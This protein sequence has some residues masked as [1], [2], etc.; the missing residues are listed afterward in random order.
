MAERFP[1]SWF[2]GFDHSDAVIA[3]ARKAADH[4]GL[5]DRVSFEVAGAA[6]FPAEPGQGYDLVCF[7]DS[8]H[9]LGD[10][11]AATAL[12][13]AGGAL[14]TANVLIFALWYWELDRGGPADRCH[15]IRM[16]PDFAFPQMEQ[17]GLAPRDWK[18]A[19]TDYLY[20][21]FTNAIS[22]SAADVAPLTR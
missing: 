17:P 11:V 21:S 1:A 7:T 15:A 9:D 19:F 12:L 5:A 6:S 2:T 4:A 16:Y 14:W 18:P 10:P 20:L 3:A 22:F 8:R 13:L